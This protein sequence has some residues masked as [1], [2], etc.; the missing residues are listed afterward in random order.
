MKTVLNLISTTLGESYRVPEAKAY[1][2]GATLE[3]YGE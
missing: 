1:R 3:V 2:L